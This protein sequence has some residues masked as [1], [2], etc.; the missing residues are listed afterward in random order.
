MDGAVLFP[1]QPSFPLAVSDGSWVAQGELLV[2]GDLSLWNG[3][4]PP[5]REDAYIINASKDTGR[6]RCFL[7]VATMCRLSGGEK[8]MT[9]EYLWMSSEP[10]AVLVK[11]SHYAPDQNDR[12][13]PNKVALSIFWSCQQHKDGEFKKY[14][15]ASSL[16]TVTT[17]TEEG[18]QRWVRLDVLAKAAEISPIELK[19]GFLSLGIFSASRQPSWVQAESEAAFLSGQ[20]IKYSAAD[21]G[22]GWVGSPNGL[23][24]IHAS[25]EVPAEEV[26]VAWSAAADVLRLVKLGVKSCRDLFPPTFI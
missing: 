11:K 7:K 16:P 1:D 17:T 12:R 14:I 4:G 19:R 10:F 26:W 18:L 5:R 25:S 2:S 13:F 3:R 20:F 22:G 6:V 21:E 9:F 23:C 8:V 15:E 24:T